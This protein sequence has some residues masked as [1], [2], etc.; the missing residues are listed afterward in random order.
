MKAFTC[1]DETRQAV[2]TQITTWF[3]KDDSHPVCWL[4]GPAGSG[5]SAI[6]RTIADFY[7]RRNEL[8]S[9][10]FFSRRNFDCSDATKFFVTLAYQLAI[11]L[12]SMRGPMEDALAK[13][14]LIIHEHFEDQFRKLIVGP[15]QLIERPV[16][17]L[18]VIDGLDECGNKAHVELLIQLLVG[19][20][21][22]LPFRL[23][24]TSRTE[25]YIESIFTGPSVGKMIKRIA[26]HEF[27]AL[28]DIYNYLQSSLLKVQI[29]RKLSPSWPTEK[30]LWQLA[31]Q[32]ENNFT[33]ASTAV[34]FISDEY[35]NPQRRLETALEAH[36]GLDSLFEQ[37][38][39][40][41]TKYPY[42]DRVLGAITLLRGQHHVSILPQL[43]QLHSIY[44]VRL[45]LRG[46]L[47]ILFVPDSDNDYIR[48]YHP[49]LFRFLTDPGRGG[50]IYFD[51][52]N[53]HRV[54]V[55]G[56]IQL[57]TDHSE[58]TSASLR[59]ACQNLCHHIDMI[60]SYANAFSEVESYLGPRVQAFLTDV[61]QR[62][63]IWM[64]GL[65]DAQGVEQVCE[66]L[67][68]AIA[69][70]TVGQAM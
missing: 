45:A 22:A 1:Q 42:F 60:L 32:S 40:D 19:A 17:R 38:L 52:I 24:A 25:G 65:E 37:V 61:P 70:V 54:I 67:H 5:K 29:T 12:P 6:A 46:C 43:L 62:L 14:P 10:F 7:D 21:H 15:V 56:C 34:E 69:C 49:S 27:D 50:N 36:N 2:L 3:Q 44:D 55:D 68:S 16:T 57:I 41:A 63:A 51:T 33:Y 66:D 28:T 58:K 59:Y 18:I 23:L 64:F 13:D 20:L 53:C 31:E 39:S 8:A 47:S 9:S 26:L 4:N 35:G 48:P 11:A 30:D